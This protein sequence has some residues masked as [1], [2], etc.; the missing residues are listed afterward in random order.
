MKQVLAILILT[1]MISCKKDSPVPKME[2]ISG[3]YNGT[4]E[5]SFYPSNFPASGQIP[6]TE[7]ATFE[8]T[9]GEAGGTMV[10]FDSVAVKMDIERNYPYAFNITDIRD[11]GDL[12][13]SATGLSRGDTLEMTGS[14]HFL[15]RSRRSFHFVGIKQ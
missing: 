7:P 14:Y 11:G 10:G 3:R 1:L 2:E 8:I 9:V 13:V 4:L 5:G 6:F 12:R 15:D